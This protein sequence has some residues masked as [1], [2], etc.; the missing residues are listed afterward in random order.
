METAKPKLPQLL[1]DITFPLGTC[2]GVEQSLV[3]Y[4]D[5][6][7]VSREEYPLFRAKQ[8]ELQLSNLKRAAEAQE[9]GR[10]ANEAALAKLEGKKPKKG[11]DAAETERYSRLHEALGKLQEDL[12][13][14]QA[15]G[16]GEGLDWNAIAGEHLLVH[17]MLESVSTAPTE[18]VAETEARWRK[19]FEASESN[20]NLAFD[21]VAELLLYLCPSYRIQVGDEKGEREPL[22][23]EVLAGLP[24]HIG[25][26]N[27]MYGAILDAMQAPLVIRATATS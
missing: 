19:N 1:N 25:D 17:T 24:Y 26:L 16:H 9:E 22:T 13:A 23:K 27:G 20:E 2:D 7:K 12:T 14:A 8:L 4:W 5:R 21:E 15:A 18:P 6:S 10:K 3:L 11:A